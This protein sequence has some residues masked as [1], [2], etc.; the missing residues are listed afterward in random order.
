MRLV[1]VPALLLAAASPAFATDSAVQTV[2]R[3]YRDFAWEAVMAPPNARGLAQQP[4]AVLRRYFTPKLASALAADAAC[5]ARRREI[6]A[7][8]FAPLWASQD[9]AAQDLSVTGGAGPGQVRVT[10]TYGATGQSIRLNFQL[11][12]T[13]AGWRVADITYPTGPSLAQQLAGSAE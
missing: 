2:A 6:C 12:P 3:L 7:L 10:F 1:I 4:R 13:K 9:P 11:A 5:A 8:D